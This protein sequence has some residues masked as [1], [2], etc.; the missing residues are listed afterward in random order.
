VREASPIASTN[1]PKAQAR[2]TVANSPTWIALQKLRQ[3]SADL[4]WLIRLRT[5]PLYLHE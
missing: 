3:S 4:T 2:I 5:F 1:C